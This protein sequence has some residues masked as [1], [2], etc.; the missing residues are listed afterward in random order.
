MRRKG[1]PPLRPS[2]APWDE[3]EPG[4]QIPYPVVRHA[5]GKSGPVRIHGLTLSRVGDTVR[6]RPVNLRRQPLQQFIEVP[7]RP[8]VLRQL[9]GVLTEWAA[10]A[11][12]EEARL[13]RRMQALSERQES[14]TLP[15][16]G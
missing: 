4:H 13:R 2:A 1:I 9:A 12:E 14:P 5:L 3:E 6:V 15:E 10:Q 16:R 7:W 11:E 8:A